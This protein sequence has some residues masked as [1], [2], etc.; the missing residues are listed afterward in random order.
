MIKRLVIICMTIGLISCA[1]TGIDISKEVDGNDYLEGIES[2]KYSG[3]VFNN[4]QILLYICSAPC[5]SMIT[6][7]APTK[8]KN[9]ANTQ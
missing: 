6:L 4:N 8:N 5:L 3:A 1:S 2:S 7:L 9:S